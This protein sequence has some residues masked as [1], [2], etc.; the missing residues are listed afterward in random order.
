MK[1]STAKAIEAHAGSCEGFDP[2]E[3]I[4]GAESW[5]EKLKD[6]P[7]NEIGDECAAKAAAC[8]VAYIEWRKR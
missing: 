4:R 5:I 8:L 3:L 7:D 6:A 1:R 2:T